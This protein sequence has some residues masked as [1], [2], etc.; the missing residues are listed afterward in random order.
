[1]NNWF[2]KRKNKGGLFLVLLFLAGP[3]RAGEGEYAVG[4]IPL[5][6]LKNANAVVRT[7]R[8]DFTIHSRKKATLYRR[9]AITILN[10]KADDLAELE[11]YYDRF[12]R[13]ASVQGY[14]YDAAGQPLKKMKLKDMEDL[15]AV[16]SGSLMEDNRLKR[17]QFYHRVYPYTVEFELETEYSS[18]LFYPAWAP[19]PRSLVSVQE[20]VVRILAPDAES[21]RYKA[22]Q[23]AGAPERSR[24]GG[25]S[26]FTWRVHHLPAVVREPYGP[27]WHEMTTYVL[28]GPRAFEMDGY[29][30]D[31]STWKD[32][33]LFIQSLR[34]DRVE[35]TPA[36]KETVH[37]LTDTVTNTYRKIE[38]LYRYLQQTTRYISIQLGVGG[39]QPFPASYVAEKGYGDCKALVN[40][41]YSLLREA[42]IRSCYA[43]VRAGDNARYITEDFPSQ[44]F[45][46]VILCVPLSRDTVWLECTSATLPCGY[47]SSFTA[48]RYALLVDEDGGVL[49]R[50]PAYGLSENVRQR[51]TD[52]RVD[53]QGTLTLRAYTRY[54]GVLQ[55]ELHGALH[56]LSR[57]K[58]KERLQQSLDFATYDIVSFRYE[59]EPSRHPRLQE[60]LEVKAQHYASLSG[61]RLFIQP[62][63]M[64]RSSRRLGMDSARKYKVVLSAEY[65]ESDTVALAVPPGYTAESLPPPQD[66]RTP[67]GTYSARVTFSGESLLY[68]RQLEQRAGEFAPSAYPELVKFYEAVYKADRARVVLVKAP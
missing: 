21:F 16:S 64:S 34:R 45:N 23:Y 9:Y 53:E 62:N 51:H 66:I 41:M 2:L 55:D 4:K 14:L 60:E 26:V 39:W 67:F 24:E 47:L 42:G 18:S 19:A 50:T 29:T 33:G 54:G 15:S 20:S 46:H 5:P 49:V 48:G 40:Y 32:F 13:I 10:E 11:E 57:D 44:Q 30:G 3:V 61:R 35:L 12:R 58:Q 63:L 56:G 59:E 22:F 43:P 7:D 65:A 37:R 17:F 38:I 31:M 25:D 52:A 27:L 68:I 6:L 1:M 28:F 36:V 8:T